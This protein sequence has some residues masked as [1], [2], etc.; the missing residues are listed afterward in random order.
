M[1]EMKVQQYK[2]DAVAELKSNFEGFRSFVFA[3]YRGLSV[4][5]ITEL[6]NALREAGAEF[7]VVKNNYA[8][9]AFK[10]MDHEDVAPYLVGPT[11]IAYCGDEAGPVAKAMIKLAKDMPVEVKGGLLDGD[12]YDA[13]AVEAF[14]KLP[15]KL[16]LVQMLMGTMQ[17]PAQNMV[18]VLNGIATKL[19]RT[20][21]AV[22]EKKSQEE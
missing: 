22:R 6:R 21:D 7:H 15:T 8:K 14:S 16:E 17:A 18:Y 13:A 19:V 2:I 9:I 4:E 12:V 10:Q 3:D 11:A 1:A 20:L 5:Q